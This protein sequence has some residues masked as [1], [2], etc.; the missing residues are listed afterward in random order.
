M[1]ICRCNTNA[2]RVC[3]TCK[4]HFKET[5]EVN[6]KV[7]YKRKKKYSFNI[8]PLSI[9]INLSLSQ[10][11][12]TYIKQTN[13]LFLLTTSLDRHRGRVFGYNVPTPPKTVLLKNNILSSVYVEDSKNP[14]TEIQASELLVTYLEKIVNVIN[15]YSNG[16]L[17]QCTLDYLTAFV[18][19]IG[20]QHFEK[21]II[22]ML[23]YKGYLNLLPELMLSINNKINHSNQKNQ[24]S[25]AIQKDV[26]LITEEIIL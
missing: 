24:C 26:L 2:L 14:I 19:R 10:Q 15:R 23:L 17:R 11:G 18:F 21:S 1:D 7:L 22:P 8:V 6:I 5:G 25:L 12:L 16:I 13:P 20:I 9:P 4:N 3:I